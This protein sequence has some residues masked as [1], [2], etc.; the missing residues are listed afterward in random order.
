MSKLSQFLTASGA[1]GVTRRLVFST[2]RVWTVPAGVKEA[3]VH[4]Y[5]GGGGGGPQTSFTGGSGG[6]GGYCMGKVSLTPGD[7]I[8]ITVG[9]GGQGTTN[10]TRNSGGASSFGALLV[11]NGGQGG[12]AGSSS[13]NNAGSGGAAT[14][15]EVQWSGN[16]GTTSGGAPGG[17]SGGLDFTRS[18][19]AYGLVYFG[20]GARQSS[21]L[22][23]N[24]GVGG[25]GRAGSGSE[26]TG[27][28]GG[29]GLVIVEF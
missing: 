23:S 20:Q 7:S 9:A 27:S 28:R 1:A 18:G 5:G 25:G 4:C 10:T 3:V 26:T 8:T 29:P 14:G 6:G 17:D 2:S 12:I 22:A 13:G 21:P 11:A 19:D 15:G 16:A 24:A